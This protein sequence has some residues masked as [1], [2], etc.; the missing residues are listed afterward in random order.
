MTFFS[1]KTFGNVPPVIPEILSHKHILTV[2]I[3]SNREKAKYPK[4]PIYYCSGLSYVSPFRLWRIGPGSFCWM[5]IGWSSYGGSEQLRREHVCSVNKEATWPVIYD[6]ELF[7]CKSFKKWRT[8]YRDHMKFTNW[9]FIAGH[10]VTLIFWYYSWLNVCEEC[11]ER[12]LNK[13]TGVICMAKS[14]EKYVVPQV[15]L[16]A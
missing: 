2:K 13:K 14:L 5:F 10:V 8:C 4:S 6:Q 11:C 9:S 1:P 7:S 12:G 15:T 16:I 3:R